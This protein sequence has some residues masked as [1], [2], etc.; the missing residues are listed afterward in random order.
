MN[1]GYTH[2]SSNAKVGKIPVTTSSKR[3][4]PTECPMLDN[5]CY[6][7]AGFHTN[8]HWDKV[9]SGERGAPIDDLCEQVR[10]LPEG[11]LWRHNVAGDLIPTSEGKIDS[12]ALWLLVAA[13]TGRRGFTY[14]HYTPEGENLEAIAGANRGGFTVNVSH[15][16]PQEALEATHGQPRVTIVPSDY[17]EQGDTVKA[18]GGTIVRCPAEVRDEVTCKTCKLC[19][20]STRDTIVGFTVHGTQAKKADIIARAA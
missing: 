12:R 9:T 5:G 20:V 17:W 13:N 15:N 2:R 3:T 6:A 8:M 10:R 16:S 11:Q 19:S 4:C 7:S 18:T 1:I 14:T